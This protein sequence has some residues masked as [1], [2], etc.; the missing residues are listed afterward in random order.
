MDWWIDKLYEWQTL[1]AGSLAILA[2]LVGGAFLRGQMAQ[3]ERHET[4]RQ[5]QRRAAAL[6]VAPLALDTLLLFESDCAAALRNLHGT[7]KDQVV[8]HSVLQAFKPPI[9]PDDIIQLLQRVV[10][11]GGTDLGNEVATI[12]SELQIQ[13]ARLRSIKS[14]NVYNERLLVLRSNIEQYIIDSAVVHAR[15]SHLLSHARSSIVPGTRL[16]CSD[17]VTLSLN[18]FGFDTNN[19]PRV[20][21]IIASRYRPNRPWYR[22]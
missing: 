22:R 5:R 21:S 8:S 1:V 2:A 9:F 19:F 15:A 4:E 18:L 14:G 12:L 7:A 3:I 11:T 16:M 17:D 6:A 13:R 10:E 20:H